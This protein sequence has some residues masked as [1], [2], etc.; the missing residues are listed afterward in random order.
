MTLSAYNLSSLL[1]ILA[2][3]CLAEAA[4]EPVAPEFKASRKL[5]RSLFFVDW[6]R[7]PTTVDE[8]ESLLLLYRVSWPFLDRNPSDIYELV[9]WGL[10][11]G[12]KVRSFSMPMNSNSRPEQIGLRKDIF[13]N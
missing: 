7:G 4:T 6:P 8:L 12:E 5:A 2:L 13:P 11:L 10:K 1:S 9:S 3:G